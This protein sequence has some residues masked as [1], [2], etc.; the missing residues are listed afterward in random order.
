MDLLI[1]SGLSG[2]GK[3]VAIK[4]CEDIGFYCV[5]N[6]PTALIPTFVD[7]AVQSQIE[8]VVLGIDIRERTFFDGLSEALR[9]LMEGGHQAEILFLEAR[10]EVLIRRYSESRRK[11]PLATDGTVLQGIEAERELLQHLRF[12]ANRVVDTSDLNV[13]E[14]R[15]IIQTAYASEERPDR[16]HIF[17]GSF[18]FKYGVPTHTDLVFDV[19]FLP[20]PHFVEELRPQTG[21]NPEVARYVLETPSGE[22]FMEHLKDFLA[23]LVPL[24]EQEGKSYLTVSLG[25]TGGRHRS[26]ATSEA[27]SHYLQQLG[28]WVT[29]QHRDIAKRG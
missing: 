28:Y 12:K 3:S 17:V 10:D 15:S 13:H 8:R 19:R 22:L 2:A 6:L 7:L 9:M 23:A 11:H 26:V 4:A 1:V 27:L 29:C 20:N 14:L 24:Y 21:Q 25:C 16:M 5:D 18:G